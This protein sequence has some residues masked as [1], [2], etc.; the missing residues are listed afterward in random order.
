MDLKK[1]LLKRI[2]EQCVYEDAYGLK[3]INDVID[4]VFKEAES[5][6]LILHG[7]IITKE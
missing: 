6:Q 5:K 4:E 2:D 1:E 7:V 3:S